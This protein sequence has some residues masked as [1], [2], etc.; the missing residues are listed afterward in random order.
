MHPACRMHISVLTGGGTSLGP[1]N[2]EIPA[3]YDAVVMRATHALNAGVPASARCHGAAPSAS[4]GLDWRSGADPNR[5]RMPTKFVG[6]H[7]SAA[8][9]PTRS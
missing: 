1:I 7:V 3:R 4:P 8:C 5:L 6:G 2:A 9:S